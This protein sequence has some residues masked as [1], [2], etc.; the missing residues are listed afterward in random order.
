MARPIAPGQSIPPDLL[1]RAYSTGVFPMADNA[2]DPEVFWVQP[3]LRGIIPL[4]GFHVPKSLAKL[5]RRGVFD[6]RFDHDFEA[7]I[8]ACANRA[9]CVPRH[10]S[11]GRSGKPMA[12]FSARGIATRW[13]PGAR[14]NWLAGF[15]A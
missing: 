4:D 15:M 6:I 5:V 3:D 10:G 9:M 11:T 8:A 14:V 12:S 1:L 13:K 2:D 7:V